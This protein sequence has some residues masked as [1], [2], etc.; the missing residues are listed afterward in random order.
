MPQPSYQKFIMYLEKTYL[1][2]YAKVPKQRFT[3]RNWF[4][5]GVVSL[6]LFVIKR[7]KS[8]M[9]NAL[10][11]RHQLTFDWMCNEI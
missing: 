9:T 8:H 6:I 2:K 10:R 4:R 7:L 3:G 5:K 1:L 11:L